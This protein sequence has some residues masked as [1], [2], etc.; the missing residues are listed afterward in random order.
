MSCRAS[1]SRS[2]RALRVPPPAL[3]QPLVDRPAFAVS[4]LTELGG[5]VEVTVDQ[6]GQVE[7]HQPARVLSIRIERLDPSQRLAQ[8]R[9]GRADGVD[10]RLR[11][12]RE[13]LA[14]AVQ[15]GIEALDHL[16]VRQ[17]G[18]RGGKA[19]SPEGEKASRAAMPIARPTAA[20][21]PNMPIGMNRPMPMVIVLAEGQRSRPQEEPAVLGPAQAVPR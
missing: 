13:A 6:A 1:C 8:R 19:R 21:K 11:R 10:L 5:H 14:G 18:R 3:D 7:R 2:R 17:V 12:W 15:I 16:A 4:L 9:Q 20:R